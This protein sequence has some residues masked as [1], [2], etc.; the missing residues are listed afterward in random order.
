VRFLVDNALSPRLAAMLTAAGH[1][2]VHVRALGLADAEDDRIFNLAR[3]DARILI[4]ADTDF[5]TLLAIYGEREPSVI[6]FR[7]GFPSGYRAQACLLLENLDGLTHSLNAGSIVVFDDK[8][9]RTR[10]L[11]LIPL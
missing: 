10:A 9:I 4:S 2:A 8:R 11:P 6:L 5:G 1:D 3:R 7:R